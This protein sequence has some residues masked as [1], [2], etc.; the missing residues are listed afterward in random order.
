MKAA[1]PKTTIDKKTVSHIAKLAGLTIPNKDLAQATE[2]FSSVL[3]YVS[4]IQKVDTKAIKDVHLSQ[5]TVNVWRE[6]KVDPTR[7][8][9][10]A[11]ALSGAKAVHNG[12]FVV[13]SILSE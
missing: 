9:T 10:Q 3:G 4:N 12:Y 2:G 13:N 8:L 7:T 5:D 1:K 6:D 11:E